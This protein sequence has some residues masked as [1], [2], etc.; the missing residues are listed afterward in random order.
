MEVY[1]VQALAEKPTAN[2]NDAEWIATNK[3]ILKPEN[4]RRAWYDAGKAGHDNANNPQQELLPEQELWAA[5]F[6]LAIDEARGETAFT[7][8][9]CKEDGCGSDAHTIQECAQR[10]LASQDLAYWC[11]MLNLDI[12]WVR[13]LLKVGGGA[14]ASGRQASRNKQESRIKA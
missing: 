14:T 10:F 9:T 8:R 1:E 2:M 3:H 4:L 12:G 5:V 7:Q 6:R 13:K 11:E